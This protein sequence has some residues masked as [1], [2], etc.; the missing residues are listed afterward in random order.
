MAITSL[1]LLGLALCHLI[2]LL[3]KFSL[4]GARASASVNQ[5]SYIYKTEMCAQHFQ[6]SIIVSAFTYNYRIFPLLIVVV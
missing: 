4:L 6:S 3:P 1:D 5:L 2:K